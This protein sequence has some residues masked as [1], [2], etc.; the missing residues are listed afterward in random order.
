MI[1]SSAIFAV[2]GKTLESTI[3]PA[4]VEMTWFHNAFALPRWKTTVVASGV[5]MVNLPPVTWSRPAGPLGSL[6]FTTRSKENLTSLAVTGSPLE[7]ACP[8]LSLHV[9]VL[10]SADEVHD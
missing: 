2:A 5:A 10:K 4:P 7:K 6:I 3:A 8:V 9:Q 1:L